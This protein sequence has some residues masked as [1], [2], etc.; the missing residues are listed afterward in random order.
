MSSFNGDNLF[1]VAVQMA[2]Q[3][4]PVARQETSYPRLSG[5]SQLILGQ[6]GAVTNAS[7]RIY[8]WTVADLNAWRMIWFSYY[9]G[10]PYLLVD[11]FGVPW[12]NVVLDSFTP[13]DRIVRDNLLGYSMK[14]TAV[15]NHL[16]TS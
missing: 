15:F 8:G 3:I 9:D 14:Y 12:P 16:T 10:V 13:Q 6:R 4:N 2:T 5:V 1:G 11:N 7:G